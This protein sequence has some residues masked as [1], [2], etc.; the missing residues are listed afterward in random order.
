MAAQQLERIEVNPD[1][2]G[3]IPYVY[4]E[5]VRGEGRKQL[6]GTDCDCCHGVSD[7][8]LT[9]WCMLIRSQYLEYMVKHLPIE[10]R[11]AAIQKYLDRNSRHRQQ[12]ES[13]QTPPEYW[14]M[15]FPDS[16]KVEKIRQEAEAQNEEKRK[17]LEAEAK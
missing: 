16:Q 13:A 17:K 14:Q 11:D 4:K 15:G 2:N 3:G 8:L 12:F 6:H 9:G 10:Q 1:Q 7:A 5:T